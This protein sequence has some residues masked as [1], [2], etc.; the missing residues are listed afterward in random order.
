MY[1]EE[2]WP[3]NGVVCCSASSPLLQVIKYKTKT[4]AEYGIMIHIIKPDEPLFFIKPG[5]AQESPIPNFAHFVL[6]GEHAGW[7]W[8]DMARFN[9]LPLSTN[10]R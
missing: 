6:A 3:E 8:A 7:I 10:V 9:I 1:P 5:F 2:V 4:F